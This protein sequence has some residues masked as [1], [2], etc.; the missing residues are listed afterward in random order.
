ME[1]VEVQKKNL[2]NQDGQRITLYRG[3]GL[4]EAAIKVYQKKMESRDLFQFTSF[5]ST[6][7]VKD[8]A[9]PFAYQYDHLRRDQGQVPVLLVMDVKHWFER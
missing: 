6:S 9:I 5:T 3:L 4:P 8:C 2:N 7:C 1:N